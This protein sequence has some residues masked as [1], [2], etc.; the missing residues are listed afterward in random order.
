MFYPRNIQ[1]SSNSRTT[2]THGSKT[3][4]VNE[5]KAPTDDSIRLLNEMQEKVL[6]N[7]IGRLT[8]NDNSLKASAIHFK[9]CSQMQNTIKVKYTYN[10]HERLVTYSYDNYEKDIQK[11]SE[12]LHK[13]LSNDIG[14]V[15]L[16]SSMM[17]IYSTLMQQKYGV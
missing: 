7:I 10:G 16:N 12:G 14:Q 2:V 4:T 5:N 8:V 3:V 17:D 9:D 11:I 13:A 6:N 15:I 1:I